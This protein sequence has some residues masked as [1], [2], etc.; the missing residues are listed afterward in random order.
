MM[1]LKPLPDTAALDA[2]IA[3]SRERPVLIFKHSRT[4]G[5]SCEAFDELHAH[6]TEAP[7]EVS[8]KV[9][10]VQSHRGV[11]D[12]AEARLGVRHATPQVIL[13]RGGVPVWNAS[14]FR[15]TAEALKRVLS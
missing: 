12:A 2:A 1:K 9:I 11:S 5:I 10:T 8:Y 13:L 3:E 15:I 6:I 14:H 7:V 4:C